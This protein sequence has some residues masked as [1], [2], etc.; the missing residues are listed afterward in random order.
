MMIRDMVKD[1]VKNINKKDKIKKKKKSNKLLP[2][3]DLI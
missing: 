3:N 1:G 2:F